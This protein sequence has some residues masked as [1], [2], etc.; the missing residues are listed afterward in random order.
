MNTILELFRGDLNPQDRM[1]PR[2]PDAIRLHARL[3]KAEERFT[4][5]LTKPQMEL[6]RQ[7]ENLLIRHQ[8]MCEETVFVTAFRL[9]VRILH[10]ALYEEE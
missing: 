6:Y 8:D 1:T 5:S 2:T 4:K 10:D 9:G 7:Y 3:M